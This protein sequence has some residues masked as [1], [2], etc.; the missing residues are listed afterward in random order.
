MGFDELIQEV[1]TAYGQGSYA[2]ALDLVEKARSEFPDRDSTLTF[3]EACFLA[4]AGDPDRSIDTLREG[5]DRGLAWHPRMLTDPDLDSVRNLD[6]WD[7]FERRSAELLATLTERRPDPLVRLA[8]DPT[9]TL[10]AVH[11]AGEIPE[12]FFAEWAAA[13]P[14]D[15]TVIA[16]VGD[17][18]IP[19]SRWAWPFDLSTDSLVQTL[20]LE[21]PTE[22]SV[23]AGFSQG[24]RLAA[25][26]A[27]NGSVEVSGL[28]LS[29]AVLTMDLWDE[30]AKRTVP[31]YV[32][33]GTE[34]LGY[35]PSLA[36]FAA[37]ETAGVPVYV[38]VREGLG[39]AMPDDLDRVI[40]SGLA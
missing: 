39:H 38:D 40:E 17:V 31:L 24:A 32:V 3:W 22:P 15:W 35:E 27:W 12:E 18:P 6:G 7:E 1:L 10:I 13:T 11:G 23:L 2:A 21:S 16:P 4:L 29:A 26:A 5:L 19:P 33:I 25:K 14:P 28:I 20:R 9:G 8:A 37:L 30:S 36:V 34:D